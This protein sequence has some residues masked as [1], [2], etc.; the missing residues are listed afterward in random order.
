[1]AMIATT[2]ISSIKVKPADRRWRDIGGFP[3]EVT[4]DQARFVPTPEGV[5]CFGSRFRIDSS[6]G[7]HSRASKPGALAIRSTPDLIH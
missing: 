1:M 2:I 7:S 6:A 3:L 5:M 4:R